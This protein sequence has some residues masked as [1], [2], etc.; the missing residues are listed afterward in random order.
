MELTEEIL[1]KLGFKYGEFP[2]MLFV[3]DNETTFEMA[4][5][6]GK[7]YG[8]IIQCDG[9][10]NLERVYI[11]KDLKTMLDVQLIITALQ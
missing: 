4:Y 1:I 3:L 6:E 2:R 5:A 7:W 10:M 9:K 11:P 8:C